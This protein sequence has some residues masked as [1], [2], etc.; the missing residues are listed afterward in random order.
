[1]STL[2]LVLPNILFKYILLSFW[3]SNDLQQSD[4]DSFFKTGRDIISG[5]RIA[6]ISFL[7]Y[8]DFHDD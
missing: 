7:L 5:D 3:I 8:L 4:I 2:I 6:L 1:M